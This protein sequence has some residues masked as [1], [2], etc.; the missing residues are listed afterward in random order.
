MS[1]PFPGMDPWLEAPADWQ[2]TH[3]SLATYMRAALNAVL[4]PPYSANLEVRCYVER[5]FRERD[6]SHIRP[7][8]VIREPTLTYDSAV[9]VVANIESSDPAL[10][11]RIT[12][13]EAREAFVEVRNNQDNRRIVS[14]L[15]ILSPTNKTSRNEGRKLYLEKQ[16]ELLKSQ[17]NLVEIDLL[18]AG[19]HTVCVPQIS[20]RKVPHF[21]YVVCLHRGVNADS[22]VLEEEYSVW[23]N[24]VR[25]RLPRIAVPLEG[26][27]PD[28]TLDLQAVFD[29]NYEEGAY[30][31]YI[32]YKVD[33][34]PP[35]REEYTYWADALLREKG[36]P[37]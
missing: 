32:D 2:G 27:L 17:V 29:R 33:P 12:P 1:G 18:R 28:V 20:L 24:T 31:S 16:A 7:D 23:L 9:G 4:P 26:N 19:R 25:Q 21:D 22:T 15:E 5:S 3:N 36:L 30:A 13:Q 34:V 37:I 10:L 14:I 6:D 11:F 35:L 8:I